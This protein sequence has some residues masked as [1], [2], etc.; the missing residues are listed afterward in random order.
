M[1]CKSG[2][3][4]FIFVENNYLIYAHTLLIKTTL[5]QQSFGPR[6]CLSFFLSFCLSVCLSLSL[7]LY[8]WLIP[9]SAEAG[10]ITQ[11]ILASLL[12]SLSHR[13]LWTTRFQSIKG[14]TFSYIKKK[15][16]K[17]TILMYVMNKQ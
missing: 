2:I 15:K 1:F 16:K 7:S 10:C 13:R 5:L 6:V 14:P 8:F 3:L 11:G 4:I 17:S 9:W 12:L